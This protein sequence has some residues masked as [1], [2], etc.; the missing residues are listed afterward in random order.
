VRSAVQRQRLPEA[1]AGVLLERAEGNPFF[2]EELTRAVVEHGEQSDRMELPDTVQAVLMARIDRLEDEPKR[3]LQTASVL[4]REFSSCLLGVIW[5]GPG[6]F[7][8]HLR[9]LKRL[10]FLYEQ[11][12]GEEPVYVFKHALT[13][14][15]AYETLL[16]SHR[17][18]LHA[19]AGRALEELFADRLEVAYD[20]LA[21]HYSKAEASEKAIEYLTRSAEKAAAIDAHAEAVAALAEALLH[22]ERLPAEERDRCLIDLLIRRAHSLHFLGRRQELVELLLQHQDRLERFHEPALAGQ[23]YFWLGFAHSF[24]GHRAEA[25]QSLQRS[26]EE[27]TRAGNEALMGRVHR[28]L[29]MEYTFSGR[30]FDEAVAHGR[31]AVA[32]LERTDDRFWLSQALWMLGQACYLAGDFD[33]ALEIAARLDALGETTG[34]RRARAE[35]ATLMAFSYATRGDWS[36]AIEAC[37]RG[38]EVSPDAFETAFLLACLG[39]AHSEGGDAAQAVPVLEQAVALADQVRSRQIRAWFRAWLGEAYLLGGQLDRAQEVASHVLESCTDVKYLVGIG[40]A[41]QVLGRVAQAQG[42]L[43]E[44]ERQLAD[45]LE[46]L[47]LVQ[48]RF[49]MGRTNLFQ[50]SLAHAQGR[51]DEAAAHASEARSLFKKLRVPRCL[52]RAEQLG[53][54]LALPR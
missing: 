50:A 40:W 23:Y 48:A 39:K 17:R 34:N 38:L 22:A 2:L 28:G 36:A 32:L 13:Q 25:A 12:G 11:T 43:A 19:T 53:G 27:A 26:L 14:E 16:T 18:A 15:V 49:E 1:L 9:E 4:G 30:P 35:A 29:G 7:E 52:E 46:A 45:A 44:A 54:E 24:L 47:D 10:E 33:L 51:D 42:S 37:Q 6:T 8:P 41:H 21:Y 5:D 3:L 31:Q 20:R